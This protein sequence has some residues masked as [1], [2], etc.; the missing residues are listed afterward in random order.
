MW[1]KQKVGD[2]F[3]FINGVSQC[4]FVPAYL[5]YLKELRAVHNTKERIPWRALSTAF[6]ATFHADD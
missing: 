4:S 3:T 6:L 2:N 1:R 5:N